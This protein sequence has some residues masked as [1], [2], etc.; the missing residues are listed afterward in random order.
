MQA[1]LDA[2][3][4]TGAKNVVIV[5]RPGLVLRPLGHPR[6]A[7]SSADPDGNGVI[8][9]NHAYPFKGDTVEQWV[10]KMETATKTL[11]VIVSE[12]G[13]DP[14]G[15][16]GPDGRAVG[17]AGA[18]GPGRSRVGLDRLGPASRG[19]PAP[20]LRLEIHAHAALRPVGQ[21][22]AARALATRTQPRRLG[23]RARAEHAA[24]RRPWGSSR[25]TETS[26]RCC[27]PG[28]SRSTRPAAP[29]PWPAAARTCG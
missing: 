26:A 20:D 18:A 2:V 27:I 9:A 5:G 7:S 24:E 4:A 12:F 6:R 1:L 19:R 25:A 16:A 23:R 13:S 14:K 17:A 3:R 11:P 29:T 28:R 10:A 8:Y 21:A 22:G 15:G